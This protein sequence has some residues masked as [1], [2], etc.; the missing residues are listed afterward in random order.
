MDSSQIYH[1]K[2]N[3]DLSKVY[4]PHETRRPPGNV[5][6]LVDNLWEWTRPEPYPSRRN[7]KFGNPDPKEALRSAHLSSPD[8]VY[9]VEFLGDPKVAQMTTDR[10]ARD[11]SDCRSLRK[12]VV[13]SLDG[14]GHRYSWV[15]Q[16]FREKGP[17]AQLFQP[18]LKKEEVSQI[19]EESD[20]LRPHREEIREAVGFWGD[21]VSVEPG[22]LDN[23]E[24]EV[25]FEYEG[26]FRLHPIE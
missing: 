20:M 18:C 17:A 25:F 6:Y 8:Q 15:S 5:S 7:A 9:R 26:G 24:G 3:A 22:D 19:F 11:H 14:D 12:Q 2:E 13:R 4:T 10:D 23:D 21:V 16:G 1:A